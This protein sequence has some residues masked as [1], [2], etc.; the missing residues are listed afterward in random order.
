MKALILSGGLGTRLRPLT[1]YTPKPLLPVANV[2]FLA[3]PLAL[4]RKHG[5]R[6]AVLCSSDLVA[7]YKNFIL[8]QRAK[9]TRL[10]CSR[11]FKEL[12][13]AGALKNAERWIDSTTF[14]LNGDI[15]T[16]TNL[17]AMLHFHRRKKSII[18][19]A[20]FP[21][22]DP[23]S[24]GLVKL[25]AGKK[26]SK[27]IEKPQMRNSPGK[28]WLINAG[29]Y[30]FEPEVFRWI[31]KGKKYSVERELFPKCLT[32]KVPMFGY[33]LNSSTCWIDI[34]TPEKYLQA[35]REALRGRIHSEAKSRGTKNQIHRTSVIAK[36]VVIGSRCKIGSNAILKN[37]VV[38]DHVQ[39]GER[40]LLENCIVG[41]G[42]RIGHDATVQNSRIIGNHSIITPFSRI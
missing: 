21:V 3:Y 32:Q 16:D 17:S 20:L 22:K 6:E 7:P 4:L 2:P 26:I 5:I 34:G 39:I 14:I 1:L 19:V 33:A 28:R 9:G 42:C 8:N 25:S 23:S 41:S 29:I 30:I 40:V 24:Y 35:N 11:E 37:S 27:F 36:D 38:L 13:T 18:T 10:I 15:L 31:P 12:G